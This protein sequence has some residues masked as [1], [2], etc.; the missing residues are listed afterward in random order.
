MQILTDQARD[1][2]GTDL[3]SHEQDTE[4]HH[5]HAGQA[6]TQTPALITT[7]KQKNIQKHNQGLVQEITMDLPMA[8]Q[9]I[10]LDILG[11]REVM[12]PIIGHLSLSM[13]IQNQ[14]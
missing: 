12:E 11:P 3:S 6:E 14:E 1:N 8:S 9:E 5:M 13:E 10:P 4:N 7:V 2:Q